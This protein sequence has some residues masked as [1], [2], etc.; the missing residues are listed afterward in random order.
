MR[1]FKLYV[2][3]VVLALCPIASL[4]PLHEG[5]DQIHPRNPSMVARPPDGAPIPRFRLVSPSQLAAYSGIPVPPTS[6]LQARGIIGADHRVLYD[7][8]EYPSKLFGR[9]LSLEPCCPEPWL[10][11][12]CSAS[13]IGPRH[14]MTARHCIYS[15]NGPVRFE[16][17]VLDAGKIELSYALDV[18]MLGTAEG[19][20]VPGDINKMNGCAQVNDWAILILE[21]RLGDRYGYVGAKEIDP[22]TQINKQLFSYVGYPTD[23]EAA[24]TWDDATRRPHRQD[25]I[26]VLRAETCEKCCPL[27]TDADSISGQSGG[28]LFSMEDG[29]VW[30]YGAGSGSADFGSTFAS[31]P[32]FVN[33]VAMARKEYP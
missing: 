25:G 9:V 13:L 27:L 21:D 31:G 2:V 15:Q 32:H 22:A 28:P 8:H 18:I 24:Y 6:R 14:A 3:T 4:A 7:T 26:S 12:T 33:A 19:I 20:E 16:P 17:N 23:K 11:R 10:G 1:S 29:L 30:Q 5:A